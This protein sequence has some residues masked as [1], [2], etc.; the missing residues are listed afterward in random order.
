M[1]IKINVTGGVF[2]ENNVSVQVGDEAWFVYTENTGSSGHYVKNST[3]GSLSTNGDPVKIGT[4]TEV[5]SGYITV[6]SGMD[7]PANS[8]LMFKKSSVANDTSL[9]GYYAEVKLSNNSTEKAELFALNSEITAS[10][11]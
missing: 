8:F 7:V 6:D 5:G 2:T 1:A 3:T 4:I 11:K 10:S 9:L